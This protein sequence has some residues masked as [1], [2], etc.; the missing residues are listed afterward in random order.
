MSDEPFFLPGSRFPLVEYLSRA[1]FFA[2]NANNEEFEPSIRTALL[3]AAVHAAE[4]AS[5]ELDRISETASPEI[6]AAIQAVPRRNIIQRLRNLDLHGKPLPVSDPKFKGGGMISGLKPITIGSRDNVAG[7]I[8]MHAATPKIR[9]SP[10]Q[11]S[12]APV[13]FGDSVSYHM[14]RGRTFVCDFAA[15]NETVDLVLVLR[16][17]VKAATEVQKLVDSAK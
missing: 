15:N 6:K 14:E 5:E 3:A 11:P 9:R 2:T 8:Q 7:M 17:F 1:A 12:K 10:N 13:D 4:S 16:Q